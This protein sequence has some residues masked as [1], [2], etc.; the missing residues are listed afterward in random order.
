MKVKL[1]N[2]D[3]LVELDGPARVDQVLKAVGVHV[4]SVIVIRGAEL[5]THDEVV[6]ADDEVELRPV[7]SGG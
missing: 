6:G 1:R 4:N 2:P 7:V 3:R 5:L